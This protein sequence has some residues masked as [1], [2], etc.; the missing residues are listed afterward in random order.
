M[1]SYNNLTLKSLMILKL[2]TDHCLTKTKFVMKTDDDMFINT[3]TLA[4]YFNSNKMRNQI[5]GHRYKKAA[6]VRNNKNKWYVYIS[7]TVCLC[8]G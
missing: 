3:M 2:V 4:E 5:V 1:D 7:R 6:P 8:R